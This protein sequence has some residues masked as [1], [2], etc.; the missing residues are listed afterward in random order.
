M[1]SMLNMRWHLTALAPNSIGARRYCKMAQ[2]ERDLSW[3]QIVVTLHVRA[4]WNDVIQLK[5]EPRL[6]AVLCS[7]M[8]AIT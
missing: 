1:T 2:G 3:E 6:Y 4:L 8:L 5:A 7:I